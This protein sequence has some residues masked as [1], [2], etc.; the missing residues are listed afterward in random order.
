MTIYCAASMALPVVEGTE[1]AR[2]C[3]LVPVCA[4][5]P[6]P[7]ITKDLAVG[8]ASPARKYGPLDPD[9]P[10]PLALERPTPAPSFYRRVL[11]MKRVSA[12]RRDEGNADSGDDTRPLTVP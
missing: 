3:A 11:C 8:G 9:F 5:P 2:V 10:G 6:T 12:W 1:G 7:R 4:L